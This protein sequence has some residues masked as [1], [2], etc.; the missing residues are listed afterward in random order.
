MNAQQKLEEAIASLRHIAT[1]A[2]RCNDEDDL[3]Q[4][5]CNCDAAQV[6]L[7]TLEQMGVSLAP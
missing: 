3:L 4:Q 6:A 2:C 7:L 5:G 1:T